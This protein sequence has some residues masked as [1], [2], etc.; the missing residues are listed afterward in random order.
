MIRNILDSLGNVIGTMTLPDDT[1]EEQWTKALSQYSAPQLPSVP[2]VINSRNV[3]GSSP[4]TTSSSQPA[5]IEGMVL[6]PEA[7]TYIALF[8]GSIYTAGASAVGEFGIY[9]NDVLISETRRDISCNLQLLGGLVTVSLNS[10]G[11]G[12]YSG[13]EITLDGNQLIDVKFRS[14]NGGTIGFKERVFTLIKVK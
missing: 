5:T 8:N 3:T 4:V 12:T 9:V 14:T 6:K 1:T 2:A 13:T 7:G 11:V 10:I